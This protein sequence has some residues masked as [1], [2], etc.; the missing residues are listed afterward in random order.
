[1]KKSLLLEIEQRLLDTLNEFL[2]ALKAERDAIISFSLEG[3]IKENNRKEEILKRLELLDREKEK[4]ASS[5][6]DKDFP[7]E[8]E[9]L[10]FVRQSIDGKAR[11][12]KSAL[13]KNMGL[14]TF[15]MDH[16]N[17]SVKKVVEFINRSSYSKGRS[18]SVMMPRKI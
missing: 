13:E 15:S 17:T 6:G 14:L 10:R 3:V 4:I 16:V 18:I 5:I 9:A 7:S 8:K 11:E 12:V 1:M 2:D